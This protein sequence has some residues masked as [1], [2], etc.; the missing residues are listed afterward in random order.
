MAVS[1]FQDETRRILARL[2]ALGFRHAIV[3]G[4]AVSART[5]PRFTR[6]VVV[7]VAVR[8]DSEAEALTHALQQDG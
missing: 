8:S 6:D 2:T 3:G 5:E 4:L 1:Q 7:A